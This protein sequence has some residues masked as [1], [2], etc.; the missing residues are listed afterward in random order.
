MVVIN[1]FNGNPHLCTFWFDILHVCSYLLKKLSSK[2]LRS[3]FLLKWSFIN[4]F[5]R[6]PQLWTPLLK[7]L[8]VYLYLPKNHNGRC[9]RSESIQSR[10]SI[11]F[12]LFFTH[13][14]KEKRKKKRNIYMLPPFD[15]NMC[16]LTNLA[17]FISTCR[18]YWRR[19]GS[20]HDRYNRL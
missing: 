9:L 7:I 20:T 17:A 1:G 10:M 18:G 13:T 2:C 8:H 15:Q 5:N 3:E 6:K 16:I 19:N 14:Q 11:S 4:G 12:V